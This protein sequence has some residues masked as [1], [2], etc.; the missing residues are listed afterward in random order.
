MLVF[1]IKLQKLAYNMTDKRKAESGLDE[2]DLT[3]EE[4]LIYLKEKKK[5]RQQTEPSLKQAKSLYHSNKKIRLS[6]SQIEAF[7]SCPTC[8]WKSHRKG[9][10]PVPTPA[11]SLNSAVDTLVKQEFDIYRKT[12]ETPDIFKENNLPY[13]KAYDHEK[14]DVWVNVFKGISYFNEKQNVEWY[15]G[16]DDLVMNERTGQLHM[17]DTKATS[18]NG[19]ILTLDNVYNNGEQYKRQLEIY[20]WLF[21]KNGFD[22][23]HIGFLMYYNGIKS[24]QT[25]GLNMSFERTLIEVA[26]DF[27]WIE[28]VTNDMVQ[29]LKQ[30][31]CPSLNINK[32]NYCTFVKNNINLHL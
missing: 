24:N 19:Q 21:K 5:G 11:F 14:L 8:F 18:K 26:L 3:C 31:E 15:G 16:I 27:S 32:C 6:R 20:G 4:P 9:I 28:Q 22:V 13:L 7:L 10:K 1:H 12:K 30:D 2:G 23:S 29:L 25:M 17:V